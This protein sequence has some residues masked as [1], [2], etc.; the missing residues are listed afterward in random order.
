MTLRKYYHCDLCGS[1]ISEQSGVGIFHKANG[2][3]E[4]VW[5]HKDCAGR[6]IC[7]GCVRGLRVMLDGLDKLAAHHEEMDQ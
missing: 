7:N 2:D 4:A 3:I 6:H 1:S 5:L